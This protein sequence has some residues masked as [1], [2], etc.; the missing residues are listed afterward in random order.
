MIRSPRASSAPAAPLPSPISAMRP[1]AS[2]S[3]PCPIT[4]SART[5]L[6]LVITVSFGLECI[7]I[8]PAGR[9]GKAGD[10]DD[11]GG[12]QEADLVVMDDRDHG[13]ALLLLLGKQSDHDGAV[14]GV[15]RG[16]RLVEDQDRQLRDKAARD[17]D[18]L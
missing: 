6:A 7:S 9:C 16:G 18:A 13:D 15:K 11:S 10:G 17:V 12:N 1:S 5:I 4:R 8:C 3:Q 14:G 2:A